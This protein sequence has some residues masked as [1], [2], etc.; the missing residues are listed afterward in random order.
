[1]NGSVFSRAHLS[2]PF[3]VESG[4]MQT[5]IFHVVL[6]GQPWAGLAGE[7]DPIELAPGDIVM[8]PFGDNHLITDTPDAP[9]RPIGLLTSTDSNGMGHLVVDGGGASTSL[10][11]GTISFDQSAANPV[12]SMLPSM[13]HE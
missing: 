6:R 2:S 13:V 5:G 11:C 4:Q 3:G 9:H 1:M 12:L 8:F 7:G 10:I